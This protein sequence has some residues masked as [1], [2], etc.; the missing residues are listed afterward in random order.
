MK[1][2]LLQLDETGVSRF[3]IQDLDDNH[4]LVSAEALDRVKGELEEELEKNNYI[5]MEV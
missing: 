2:I 3:I 1:Q 4:L 5:S